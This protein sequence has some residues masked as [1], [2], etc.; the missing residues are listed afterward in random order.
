M[1]KL[2]DTFPSFHDRVYIDT[3]EAFKEWQDDVDGT[4]IDAMQ[5]SREMA[6]KY[7][8]QNTR[9]GPKPPV[10]E[11]YSNPNF[12]P[13]NEKRSETRAETNP[14]AGRSQTSAE[15]TNPEI[16]PT[17]FQPFAIPKHPILHPLNLPGL[18]SEDD[19]V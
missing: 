13:I 11:S 3:D 14:E 18:D 16:R 8:E 5:A 9:S 10:D 6:N 4:A 17:D 1:D 7:A 12:T 2:K 15:T 19:L